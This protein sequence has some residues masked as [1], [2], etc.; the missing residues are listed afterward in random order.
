MPSLTIKTNCL[1]LFIVAL[2]VLPFA[3]QMTRAAS[4]QSEK[5]S[6]SANAARKQ[7]AIT[8]E[9]DQVDLAVTVYNS[10]IALVRD[11]RQIH[12]PSGMIH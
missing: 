6:E 11:V 4:P 9:K 5:Q 10:N 3:T 2:A 12:L 7:P 1:A 8:T